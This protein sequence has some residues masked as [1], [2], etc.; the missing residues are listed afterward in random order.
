MIVDPKAMKAAYAAIEILKGEIDSQYYRMAEAKNPAAG[1]QTPEQSR[2][3]RYVCARDCLDQAS[4]KLLAALDW[5]RYREE[6]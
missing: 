4:T 5:L 2:Y 3:H 1:T 6:D